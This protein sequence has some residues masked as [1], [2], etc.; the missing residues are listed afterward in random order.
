MMVKCMRCRKLLP[1]FKM[2]KIMRFHDVTPGANLNQIQV[3]FNYIVSHNIGKR[4]LGY[5]C[6]RCWSRT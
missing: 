5:M 3:E 2:H 4:F 6:V 1:E